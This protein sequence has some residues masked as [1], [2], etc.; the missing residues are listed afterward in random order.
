MDCSLILYVIL[1]FVQEVFVTPYGIKNAGT[2]HTKVVIFCVSLA[3]GLIW[4]FAFGVH[5]DWSSLSLRQNM[6]CLLPESFLSFVR[7]RSGVGQ[8]NATFI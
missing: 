2:R 6:F 8:K 5:E 4:A 1:F 3:F 7:I